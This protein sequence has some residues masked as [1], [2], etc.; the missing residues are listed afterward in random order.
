MS[1]ATTIALRSGVEIENPVEVALA[2]L[3]GASSYDSSELPR[4]SFDERDLRH[5][6]RGGARISSQQIAAI[7]VRRREI[8]AAL[9]LIEPNASLAAPSIRWS[10]LKQLFDAFADVHGGGLSKATKALHPKRPALIPMLD[11]VVC[12]YLTSV[13]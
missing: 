2:F 10:A 8:E 3:G 9:R 1:P 5:A 12:T 4:S 7:L 13:D 6:N 11:S